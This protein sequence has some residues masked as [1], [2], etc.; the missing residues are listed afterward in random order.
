MIIIIVYN[1]NSLHAE[2]AG[3]E[4][5]GLVVLAALGVERVAVGVAEH[6]VPQSD[7]EV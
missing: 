3:G 2:A 7:L 6:G 4:V 1:S 5:E